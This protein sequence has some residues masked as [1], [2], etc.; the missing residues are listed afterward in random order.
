LRAFF[1]WRGKM[2]SAARP[3]CFALGLEGSSP[4]FRTKE[5]GPPCGPFV[6][7]AERWPQPRGLRASRSP[8]GDESFLRGPDATSVH[9]FNPACQFN[10]IVIGE[11]CVASLSTGVLRRNRPSGLTS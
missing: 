2:A 11:D 4:L 3:S 8:S 6:W 5:K 10:T 1:I 9:R 7:R